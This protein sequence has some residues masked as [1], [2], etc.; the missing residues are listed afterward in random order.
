MHRICATLF[1]INLNNEILRSY[2][3]KATIK[4]PQAKDFCA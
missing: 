2:H 1:I 3:N 4:V